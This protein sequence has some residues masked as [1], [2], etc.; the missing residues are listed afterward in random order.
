MMDYLILHRHH[1]R[2]TNNN[3]QPTKQ[4]INEGFPHQRLVYV[5][6]SVLERCR[7]LPMVEELHVTQ[8]GLYPSA[9][10]HYTD[11]PDGAEQAILI[12]CFDGRGVVKLG[13]NTFPMERGHVVLL[14]ALEAH[15]YFADADQ[16]WS[17]LWMHI[18]GRQS[19]RALK[20]LGVDARKPLL[21]IPDVEMMHQAFEDVYAC[22]NYHY[23]DAGLLAMTG[24][25]IRFLGKIKLHHSNPHREQQAVEDRILSTVDFME[26][27]LDMPLTL[28]ALAARAG[29]SIPHYSKLF[30]RRTSQSPMAFFL[31][32]KVRK[33]CELLGETHQSVKTIASQLGY[34]DPYYFS[35]L[36]KKIQGC[37]PAHYRASVQ[38]GS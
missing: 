27:H 11:R 30:K 8:I 38:K 9:A 37:S 4:Q 26:Q 33:A 21:Y 24:E 7:V 5:P 36:F 31:Q 34:D 22:L 29:Q 20:N 35:R 17:I 6:A 16:P 14:P 12:Y 28:A 32:L 18:A 25:L 2:M 23:S 10:H 3:R 1:A 13:R 15:T 19:D